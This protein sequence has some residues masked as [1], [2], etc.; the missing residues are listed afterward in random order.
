M[1]KK[2]HVGKVA[3]CAATALCALSS[4]SADL[5]W[6]FDKT[7]H[8]DAAPVSVDSSTAHNL[9]AKV[10]SVVFTA[11]NG[12][13]DGRIASIGKVTGLNLDSQTSVGFVLSFR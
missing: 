13:I 3:F 10:C 8:V 6:M 12:L 9:Y 4:M 1:A 2:K 11:L 5:P 7:R